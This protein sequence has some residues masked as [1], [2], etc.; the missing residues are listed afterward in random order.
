MSQRLKRRGE[1][2]LERALVASRPDDD[3]LEPMYGSPSIT[4][5]GPARLER[6]ASSSVRGRHQVIQEDDEPI[7][8]LSCATS[9]VLRCICVICFNYGNSRWQNKALQ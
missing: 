8:P 4:G 9:S 5:L 1:K 6:G 2:A 7:T 3:D